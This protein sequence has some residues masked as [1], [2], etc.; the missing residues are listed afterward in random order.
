[1]AEGSALSVA[2]RAAAS[3]NIAT[4]ETVAVRADANTKAA[5][6]WIPGSSKLDGKAF[7]VRSV[8]SVTSAVTSQFTGA[9]Y[10]GTSTVVASNVKIATT[11]ATTFASGATGTVELEAIVSWDGVGK[12]LNGFYEGACNNVA[13]TQAALTNAASANPATEGLGFCVSGTFS[14]SSVT[15][16]F[17]LTELYIS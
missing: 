16:S 2:K 5:I 10:F 13:V 7:R 1:M 12:V 3:G 4:T 15:N 14:V 9:L 17:T 6:A 11:A 8:I